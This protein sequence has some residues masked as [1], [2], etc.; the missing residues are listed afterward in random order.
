M[1]KTKKQIR[2][3]K[4]RKLVKSHDLFDR[5]DQFFSKNS[6]IF[7][8]ISFFFTLLFSFLLFNFRVSE[9]GDDSA[10]ILRAFDF[11]REFKLPTFQ[12]PLYPIFL[13]LFIFLFG[14]NIT[15]LKTLSLGS[16][17]VHLYLFY[18]AF[19]NSV[20]SFLLVFVLIILSFNAHLLYYSSQT[21]SEAFY[22]MLQAVFFFYFFKYF[23]SSENSPDIKSN[24]SRYLLLG[25]VLLSLGLTRS[26]GYGGFVAVALFFI[27]TFQWKALAYSIGGFLINYGI[28]DVF[29]RYL[30]GITTSQFDTQI[31]RL[32]QKNPFDVSK[33]KEDFVGFIVRFWD[34]S[35]LYLSKHLFKFI[36]IRPEATDI[37][38]FLTI[39]VYILFV[40][41]IYFA[42]KKNRYLLFTGIYLAVLMG[43]TFIIVQARWDQS[44]LII[45]YLP[46]ILLFLLSGIYYLAKVK[47]LKIIKG[48]LPI[49]MV[50]MFFSILQITVK[51]VRQNEDYLM[52]HLSGNE[53]YGMSR[54]WIN[55]IKMS[56]WVAKN[57]PENEVIAC[58]KPSISFIYAKRKFYGIYRI[59]TKDPDELLNELNDHNVKYVIMASLRKYPKQKTEYTINTVKRYLYYIQQK[60]PKKIRLVKKIG[61][62]EQAYLFEL[63][64]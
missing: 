61:T 48:L 10:Y 18:R 15:F 54:D 17:L 7:F 40:V 51:K 4:K 34:N 20:S 57:I 55:Y 3:T 33:G 44:R 21:Y 38:V 59:E 64:Y 56:Q 25:T 36:G 63:V 62:D 24:W 50:I 47:S 2:N 45:V 27:V 53:F 19:K 39:L 12:G 52:N 13:S 6:L 16:I 9:A 28:F 14:L 5:L 41:A 58:R 46:L 11:A 8:W 35:N 60:Y 30:F 31:S 29:K 23:V 22:M 49:F 1:S 42:F 26:I 37:K 32:M 43:I